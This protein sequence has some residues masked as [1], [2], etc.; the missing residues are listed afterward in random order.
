VVHRSY[1]QVTRLVR[2]MRYSSI[3]DQ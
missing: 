2:S 1:N 3:V